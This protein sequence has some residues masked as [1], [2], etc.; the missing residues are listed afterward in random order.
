MG[1]LQF[2][3]YS[4]ERQ[5]D[6]SEYARRMESFE[7][8]GAEGS[9]MSRPI[10]VLPTMERIGL[11][12]PVTTANNDCRAASGARLRGR[13][14]RL[15]KAIKTDLLE[16]GSLEVDDE[17]GSLP[18]VPIQSF[19]AIDPAWRQGYARSRYKM[20]HR[21]DWSHSSNK[22][23]VRL[24]QSQSFFDWAEKIQQTWGGWISR[25]RVP[26]KIASNVL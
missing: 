9:F 22:V 12:D 6:S 24:S 18:R 5:S 1:R 21:L 8:I 11:A 17:G 15:E 25:Q 2:V 23:T 14:I 4:H 13:W 16:I 20:D 7:K 19:R 10:R 26:W 3:P